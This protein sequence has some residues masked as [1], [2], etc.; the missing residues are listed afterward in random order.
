MNE[1]D[2][3]VERE[4]EGELTNCPE[5]GHSDG[6]SVEIRNLIMGGIFVCENCG[7]TLDPVSHSQIYSDID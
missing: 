2:E 3:Q 5:C 6:E 1:R 4:K 7:Y